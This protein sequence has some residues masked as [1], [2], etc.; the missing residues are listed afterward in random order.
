[1]RN[2]KVEQRVKELIVDRMPVKRSPAR[3]RDEDSLTYDLGIDSL[4]MVQLVVALEKEF[5][6]CIDDRDLSL[7]TFASVGSV[8][9]Y[10]AEKEGESRQDH[11]IA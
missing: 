9:R 5:E 2:S 8:V 4:G 10:V 6:I 7:D 11:H 3:L 1:M